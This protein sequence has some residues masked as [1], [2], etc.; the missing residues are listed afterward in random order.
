M[1]LVARVR[2]TISHHG[3]LPT[4]GPVVAA[5]SGGP[6]SM[7]LLE[8]LSEILGDDAHERLVVAH[9]DHGLRES[10]AD[11]AGFVRVEC[12]RRGLRFVLGREDVAAL[13][14][15]RKLSTEAAA[16]EARYAFLFRV[17]REVDAKT[18]ALGHNA[19]DQAETVLLRVFR[20]AGLRGVGGM[21]PSRPAGPE[22]PGVTLIRPLIEIARADIEAFVCE[23]D[24]PFRVDETNRDLR[25]RRNLLRHEI[26]P[27]IRSGLQPR[28][29]E[30]LCRLAELAR[31]AADY[32]E[33]EAAAQIGEV[34][35]GAEFLIGRG[36]W[37]EL[38]RAL[39][40]P[41]L[42]LAFE[43]ASG[44]ALSRA[45]V[46]AVR[47][48]AEGGEGHEGRK[49]KEVSLPGG[50]SAR[51]TREG[52]TI[53]PPADGPAEDIAPWHVELSVPGRAPLPDGRAIVAEVRPRPAGAMPPRM[54]VPNAQFDVGDIDI[55]E[56]ADYD[57]LGLPARLLVRSRE[58]GDEFH[59]LGAP[60]TKSVKSFLIDIKVP[61]E[62]RERVPVVTTADG[63]V[64]WLAPFRLDE[65][66]RV[67]DSTAE[68]LVLKLARSAR[69]D[70]AG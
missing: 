35:T 62:E 64:V 30:V 6:D 9:L 28:A 16:R 40:G 32:F 41:V 51:S 60:G 29:T 67:T 25:F 11:D 43:S 49:H 13:A 56:W 33:S 45:H 50:W 21:R 17:A 37:Q 26:L 58:P 38:P 19:D 65:R 7:T 61:R 23:R 12:E 52:T 70:R 59:P 66:A 57:A 27:R 36:L 31:E 20:G 42:R 53:L 46:E 34:R 10:A 44:L 15:E 18:I 8:V 39:Q 4:S 54:A 2:D 47:G 5:V 14:R 48:I 1:R 3:M 55:E 63:A 69:P 68:V 22:A 24:V